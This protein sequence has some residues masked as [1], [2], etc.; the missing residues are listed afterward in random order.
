MQPDQ[1]HEAL[2]AAEPPPQKPRYHAGPKPLTPPQVRDLGRIFREL[3]SLGLAM[4][5][6]FD[7]KSC[8]QAAKWIR[9]KRLKIEE[10]L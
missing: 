9:S 4:H 10:P 3:E 5:T 2:V 7:P 1:D 8:R 6:R